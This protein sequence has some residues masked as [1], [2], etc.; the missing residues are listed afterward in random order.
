ML[1]LVFVRDEQVEHAD[2]V[3]L[4][5]GDVVTVLS[6]IAGRLKWII[7]KGKTEIRVS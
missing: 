5:D 1:N 7:Q 2:R 4:K 6:P 3:Q